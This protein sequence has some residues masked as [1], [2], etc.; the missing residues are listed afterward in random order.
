M[1]VVVDKNVFF[2]SR[3]RFQQIFSFPYFL[4]TPSRS[5]LFKH[6]GRMFGYRRRHQYHSSR[7]RVRN[8]HATSSSRRVRWIRTSCRFNC[9]RAQVSTVRRVERDA[10]VCVFVNS[11]NNKLQL[12]MVFEGMLPM[13]KSKQCSSRCVTICS[14][15]F[16]RHSKLVSIK[17]NDCI[18]SCWSA[19]GTRI[20]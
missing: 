10:S 12:I 1:A 19:R 13:V 18:R 14:A 20:W 3:I 4:L 16:R 11:E 6:A 17:L 2:S 5:H 8:R 15:R 7:F 9:F